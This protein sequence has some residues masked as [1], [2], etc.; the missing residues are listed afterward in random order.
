MNPRAISPI[1]DGT[2]IDSSY[3][4]RRPQTESAPQD[5]IDQDAFF[6]PD[7]SIMDAQVD[8]DIVVNTSAW[9]S[10]DFTQ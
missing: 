6:T 8:Y 2:I 5:Q 4:S 10:L 3:M 9:V 1:G 7:A